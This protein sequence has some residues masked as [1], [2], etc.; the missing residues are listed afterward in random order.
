[1]ATNRL[2]LPPA[3]VQTVEQIVCVRNMFTL[4]LWFTYPRKKM[5]RT[6]FDYRLSAFNLI[7]CCGIVLAVPSDSSYTNAFDREFGWFE[8][9]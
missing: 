9:T 8:I 5:K 1:M 4:V 7:T 6:Q 3:K 2:D